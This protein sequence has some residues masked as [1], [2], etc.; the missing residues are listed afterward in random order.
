MSLSDELQKL[1]QLHSQGVINDR[2][3]QRGKDGLLSTSPAKRLVNFAIG[4][5]ILGVF[6]SVIYYFTVF[7]SLQQKNE[8]EMSKAQA[9]FN[10]QREQQRQRME[11][12]D[13]HFKKTEQEM[14]AFKKKN[15]F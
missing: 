13:K 8:E 6:A 5:V 12:F 10:M 1:H 14:D 2:E 4:F 15:G 9:E 11:N 3:Y 7:R